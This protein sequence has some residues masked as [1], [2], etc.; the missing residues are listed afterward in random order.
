MTQ[1]MTSSGKPLVDFDAY[2]AERMRS[3]TPSVDM[4]YAP[5]MTQGEIKSYFSEQ[6]SAFADRTPEQEKKS[7]EAF[8]AFKD[9][10]RQGNTKEHFDALKAQ[11]DFVNRSDRDLEKLA[12]MRSAL[13]EGFEKKGVAQDVQKVMFEKFDRVYSNV[14]AIDRAES[15]LEVGYG[16]VSRNKGSRDEGLSH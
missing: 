3:Y 8:F 9:L 12:S 4:G 5:K 1:A 15:I 11:P 10:A 13:Q 6:R 2:M 7:F 14:D 16:D